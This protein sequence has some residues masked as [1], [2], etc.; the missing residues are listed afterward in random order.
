L[1]QRKKKEEGEEGEQARKG[2]ANTVMG[3][4]LRYLFLDFLKHKKD[5][6]FYL[7]RKIYLKKF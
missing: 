7:L 6:I 1:R 3:R 5:A 2:M 4:L